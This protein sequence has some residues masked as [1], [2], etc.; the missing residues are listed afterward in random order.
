MPAHDDEHPA[1]PDKNASSLAKDA[2]NATVGK[3]S[4]PGGETGAVLRKSAQMETLPIARV[5]QKSLPP[6]ALAAD[7][8]SFRGTAKV[9]PPI[10][11]SI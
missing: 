1:S 3:P 7:V 9:S 11:L 4:A 2:Q 6:I 8:A 10:F 5:R